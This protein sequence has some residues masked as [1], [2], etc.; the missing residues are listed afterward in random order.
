MLYYLFTYLDKQFDIPGAGVFQYISF[1]AGVA[2]VLSLL[3]T[4]TFGSQ[5]IAFLRRKQVGEDIRDLG[6][7]GQMQKRGTPTM[8]GLIIIAAILVPTLLMAKLDNVYVILLIATTVWLGFIGF[9][10][11]YIKVFKK[12]KEGLRAKFKLLGQIVLGIIVGVVLYFS[13][14]I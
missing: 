12:N 10:D 11:D 8:G 13:N 3:I 5:L 1:R 9:L 7:E 4:I 2:A 14:D 6:L